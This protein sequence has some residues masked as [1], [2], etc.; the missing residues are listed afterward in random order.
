[1]LIFQGLETFCDTIEECWD[2]D[3]EARLSAGCVEERLM[4]LRKAIVT[5]EPTSETP[6]VVVVP[7]PGSSPIKESSI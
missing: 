3:A 7:D 1:M 2:H 4:T 6:A 5:S